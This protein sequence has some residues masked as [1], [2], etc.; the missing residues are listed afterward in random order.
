[1]FITFILIFLLELFLL[2]FINNKH[3]FNTKTKFISLAFS[4]LFLIFYYWGFG[5]PLIPDDPIFFSFENGI[6]KYG[7]LACFIKQSIMDI[8][9]IPKPNNYD[10]ETIIN[11]L[12]GQIVDNTSGDKKKTNYPDIILILNESFFDLSQVTKLNREDYLQK[13]YSI[14][15]AFYGYT[16]V[17]ALKG[18]TNMTEYEIFTGNSLA[19]SPNITPFNALNLENANSTIHY[20]KKIGYETLSIH[21]K[22]EKNY[23]RVNV[24][25]QL[26][27]DNIYFEEQLENLEYWDKRTDFATDEYLFKEL[28]NK[29]NSMGEKPRFLY[30]LTMQNHATYEYVDDKNLIT[31]NENTFGTKN[32]SIN[33]YLSCI[34]LTD[35]AFYDLIEYY[36]N[37]DRDVIICMTGD[38][39][40]YIF[41][42][43][44]KDKQTESIYKFFCTPLIIW[45]NNPDLVVKEPVA[46]VYG[47]Y[48]INT[49]YLLPTI[50]KNAGIPTSGYQN[51][52]LGLQELIPSFTTYGL[53]FDSHGNSYETNFDDSKQ[54][55]EMPADMTSEFNKYLNTEYLNITNPTAVKEYFE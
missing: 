46:K 34:K 28:I 27:F 26:G 40:P 43:F 41:A 39:S 21:P 53:V 54:T 17:P 31:N 45:S 33:E 3:E 1:M 36:K 8:N 6:S 52:L 44:D 49:I 29:Y 20:L 37:V 24:Y 12:K 11:E 50:M 42:E 30:A 16:V 19:V 32:H 47:E 5:K 18:G 48:R 55:E 51:Q 23:N 15:N 10:E 14:D 38:H 4:G 13:F 22:T 7:Y 2:F 9:S 25:P 35:N